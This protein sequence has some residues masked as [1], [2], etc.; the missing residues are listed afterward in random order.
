MPEAVREYHEGTK[1]FPGAT[2][3]RRVDAALVPKQYK[4]YVDI[5][6]VA[7][8]PASV[9]TRT[10]FDLGAAT[11]DATPLTLPE[12]AAVLHYSAGV[13]RRR[14]VDGRE[15]E[16]RAASCTG[17]LYHLELYVACGELPGAL[18]AGLYHFDAPAGELRLLHAGD[19]R[20]ALAAACCDDAIATAAASVVVTSTFWRN[21]WR[22]EERAYRHVWWDAGTLLANLVAV[23]GAHGLEL[24]L[25]SAFIDRDLNA[26]LGLDA[27]KEAAVAVV[28]FG[29]ETP[30]GAPAQGPL[31]ALR[32]EALSRAEIE[33]P[34]IWQTHAATGLDGCEAVVAWRDR[35]SGTPVLAS[36][37]THP[38]PQDALTLEASIA[39]RGSARRFSAAPMALESMQAVLAAAHR[40]SES[41]QARAVELVQSLVIVNRVEGLEA[42]AYALAPDGSLTLL[43]AGDFAAEAAHLALDQDAA[44]SA[45]V[46]LYFV[47]SASEVASS[48]GER[49]YRAVQ[50]EAGLRTGRAYLAA[51]ALGLK[52]TGLTFYEDEVAR[53]FGLEPDEAL[54]LMLVV[55][56]A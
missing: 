15:L 26:L 39:K 9:S 27:R 17:A 7:L 55:F 35:A 43:K 51:T 16:F 12:L 44:G 23:A 56:G 1:L 49:G 38:W 28:S 13:M 46:N 29:A 41:D 52:A 30:A 32:T 24:R 48:L 33:Y 6:S 45:A 11:G 53:F 34:L 50:L 22:Y 2:S 10:L 21:A 54:V 31:P 20:H 5:P 3:P 37:D 4:R 47:A 8:P 14:T 25:R 18:P 42:G 19:H 40:A 36:A